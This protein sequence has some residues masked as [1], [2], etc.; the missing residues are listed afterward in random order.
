[1][2]APVRPQPCFLPLLSGLAP[3]PQLLEQIS[4][5]GTCCSLKKL[6]PHPQAKLVPP[7]PLH[8]H[9]TL[10]RPQIRHWL[11]FGLFTH[12]SHPPALRGRTWPP[13]FLFEHHL[14]RHS[15]GHVAGAPQLFIDLRSSN[16]EVSSGFVGHDALSQC[17]MGDSLPGRGGHI[18]LTYSAD[19]EIEG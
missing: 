12:L 5:S 3:V 14:K 6:P 10:F 13:T 1:M 15:S 4:T 8:S 11:S 9:C 18:I 2:P 7:P 16:P 19:M 17:L